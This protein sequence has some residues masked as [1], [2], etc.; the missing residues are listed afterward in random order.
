[1]RT[2]CP[3]LLKRIKGEVS[4]NTRRELAS[5]AKTETDDKTRPVASV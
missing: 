5:S 1:M 3:A 2:V 4:R